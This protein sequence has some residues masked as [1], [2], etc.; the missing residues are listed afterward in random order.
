[1]TEAEGRA[2][3]VACAISWLGTPFHDLGRLKGVGVDC[4]MF[5]AEVFCEAG[6]VDPVEI[7]PYSPQWHMNRSE[8]KY[9]SYIEKFAIEIETDKP[10]PGD[11]LLYRFGRAFSHGAIVIEWP[12]LIHSRNP[13]GVQYE[14]AEKCMWLAKIGEGRENPAPPRPFKVFSFWANKQ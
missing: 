11:V 10:Q 14:D 12:L 13:G 6:I 4:A 9:I 3:V 2:A 7:E 1:M 8:E 5:L